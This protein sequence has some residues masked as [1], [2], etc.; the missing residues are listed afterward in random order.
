VG[1]DR[2]IW[3]FAAL[4]AIVP[5]PAA[6]STAGA[7]AAAGL[8]AW[9][10]G[11]STLAGEFEQTLVSGALGAGLTEKGKLWL[12]RPGRLRWDYTRPDPKIAIVVDDRT[13]LYLPEDRQLIRGR[14]GAEQ[15]ALPELL[16]SRGRVTEL[17]DVSEVERATGDP[18]ASVRLK[19]V[20]RRGSGSVEHVVL[21]LGGERFEILG[22]EV[23]DAAG[24]RM[25]YR[26]S[27]WRRNRGI[28]AGL[29]AFEP[30][31]GTEI[32]DQ[33]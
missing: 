31:P 13:S 18:P 26:F 10:D 8:Q 33:N 16:A 24:N 15:A 6:E 5:A 3:V 28:P 1:R 21:L 20:P 17:F 29:F 2:A 30:P 27:P 12:E 9:L 23:L 14:L 4:V 32:V 25:A 22:A 7:R 19:L 11:T